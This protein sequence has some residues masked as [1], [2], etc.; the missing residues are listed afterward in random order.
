MHPRLDDLLAW[1]RIRVAVLTELKDR[2]V[3]DRS[4]RS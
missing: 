3:F 1:A 2:D 4:V